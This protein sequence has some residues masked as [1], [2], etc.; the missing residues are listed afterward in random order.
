MNEMK[1]TKGNSKMKKFTVYF[2]KLNARPF[3]KD[4]D[5]TVHTLS[6]DA[7]SVKRATALAYKTLGDKVS[8]V[9]VFDPTAPFAPYRI[10]KTVFP[11]R[12]DS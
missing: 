12:M 6:V 1:N 4:A 3:A 2:R 9:K 11:K 7:T 10:A 8:I 5:L